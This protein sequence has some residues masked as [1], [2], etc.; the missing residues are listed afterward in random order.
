MM[1]L[2]AKMKRKV[3]LKYPGEKSG[4]VIVINEGETLIYNNA[5]H[6]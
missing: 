5:A 4:R 3:F 1:Y 2:Q 6:N